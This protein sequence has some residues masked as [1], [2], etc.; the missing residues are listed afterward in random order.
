V[1]TFKLGSDPLA[2]VNNQLT[3]DRR[4]FATLTTRLPQPGHSYQ[5]VRTGMLVTLNNWYRSA[6]FATHYIGGEYFTRNHRSD[7][8]AVAPFQPV[9]RA[10]ERRAFDLLAK[11]IFADDAFAFPPALLQRLG[12]DRFVHWQSDPNASGRLDLPVDLFAEAYQAILLRQMWQ[13][14]VLARLDGIRAVASTR[15]STMGLADLFDWTDAA[16]WDDFDSVRTQSVPEV[17]RALQH[18]YAAML[19]GVMLHPEP[20]T[21]SDASALARH[22]LAMLQ[23]RL[24]AVLSSGV[25]DETTQANFEDIRAEISQA[26]HATT[27][28]GQ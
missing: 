8:G 1:G 15:A 21:P 12:A 19:I 20:G 5:D 27:L 23:D 14:T 2:F 9:A 18:Y 7:P 17:H 28:T 6:T 10:D 26:L 25:A 24:N 4:L 16:V 3:I 22:H 11:D 13:P